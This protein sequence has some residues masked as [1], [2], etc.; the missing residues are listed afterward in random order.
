M[1]IQNIFVGLIKLDYMHVLKFNELYQSQKNFLLV[2]S[3]YTLLRL[4]KY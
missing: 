3:I 2:F 1:L 4:N